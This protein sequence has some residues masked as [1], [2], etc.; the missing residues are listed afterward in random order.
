MADDNTQCRVLL[1]RI[2]VEIDM[3]LDMLSYLKDAEVFDRTIQGPNYK[4]IFNK[5]AKHI[6]EVITGRCCPES[7]NVMWSGTIL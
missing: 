5:T 2:A 3:M 4:L 6:Y 7:V 1:D